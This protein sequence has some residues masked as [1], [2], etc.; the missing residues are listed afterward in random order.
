MEIDV[1]RMP[2]KQY[3]V[4]YAKDPGWGCR[5]AS[6]KLW[7]QQVGNLTP[8]LPLLELPFSEAYE[9]VRSGVECAN[10]EEKALETF[11]FEGI[12]ACAITW[13]T[14][15]WLMGVM[16]WLEQGYPLTERLA[17][18]LRAIPNNKKKYSQQVRHRAF[19][20][21]KKWERENV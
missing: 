11:P 21:V 7:F 13:E 15:G 5:T 14:E 9:I 2:G 3:S 16:D 1:F 4:T 6:G 12:V 10:L 19:S 17:S 8:L 18:L 20:L